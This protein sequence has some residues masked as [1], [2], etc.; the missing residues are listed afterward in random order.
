LIHDF[1]KAYG[2]TGRVGITPES[3]IKALLLRALFAI[4]SERQLCKECSLNILYRWFIDWPIEK[5][6]WTPEAFSMNRQR[7]EKHDL[8]NKFFQRVVSEG[9][10][11]GLIGDDRFNV[12]GTLIRSL[13][14]LRIAASNDPQR[15]D[16][17]RYVAWLVEQRHKPKSEAEGLTGYDAQRGGHWRGAKPSR[18][19][20]ATLEN[21][22]ALLIPIAK[23]RPRRT[24]D[25][26]ARPISSRPSRLAGRTTT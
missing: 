5:P 26:S 11:N 16:L 23:P 22:P 4:P 14:G 17:L 2:R 13:T 21:C 8:V 24:F 19:R 18:S 6:M 20:D 3:L 1:N 10:A 12:D 7:F 25:S 9:I 15:V